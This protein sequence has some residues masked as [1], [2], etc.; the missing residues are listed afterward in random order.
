MP[1]RRLR[2][3]PRVVKRAIPKYNARGKADRATCKAT[4]NLAI[5]AADLPPDAEP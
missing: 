3:T 1:A 2:I 5:L 4:I